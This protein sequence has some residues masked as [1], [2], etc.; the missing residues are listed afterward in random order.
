MIT[1]ENWH[2]LLKLNISIPRTQQFHSQMYCNRNT[3]ACTQN[4]KYK[5]VRG[6]PIHNN[7]QL[8]YPSA[9][10]WMNE[11]SYIHTMEYY[12]TL[13]MNK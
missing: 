12:A 13:R 2:Y 11:L 10:K 1:L 9:V 7:L 8:E 5:N 4:C 6:I 3:Y